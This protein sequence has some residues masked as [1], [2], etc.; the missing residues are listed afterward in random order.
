MNQL[1]SLKTI[2]RNVWKSWSELETD[3]TFSRNDYPARIFPYK[4]FLITNLETLICLESFSKANKSSLCLSSL[5][6][7]LECRRKLFDFH[8]IFKL[9]V[10]LLEPT[11]LAYLSQIL[12][13]SKRR[14]KKTWSEKKTFPFVFSCEFVSLAFK[15]ERN[16]NMKDINEAIKVKKRPIQC[17]SSKPNKQTT[18]KTFLVFPST[19]FFASVWRSRKILWQGKASS[20]LCRE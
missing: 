13:Q 20:R 6:R 17:Y 9:I 10:I 5:S 3:A 4:K 12:R 15:A 11:F 14:G 18:E 19:T 7:L 2:D 8:R 1:S 16:L